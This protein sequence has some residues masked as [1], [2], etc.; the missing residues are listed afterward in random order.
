MFIKFQVQCMAGDA[1][2]PVM[3]PTQIDMQNQIHN[4]KSKC[5]LLE[6]SPGNL[7]KV[8]VI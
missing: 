8:Q 6:F 4:S 7:L 3:P 1:T 5:T 2:L